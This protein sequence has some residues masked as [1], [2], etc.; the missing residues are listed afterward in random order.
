MKNSI[1]HLHAV[2]QDWTRELKFY[3]SETPIFKKRLEEIVQKNT[4]H[5]ILAQVEHFE[6]KF[7]IMNLHFDELI[8][9]LRLMD[10]A[11][12]KEAT[13]KPNF[14]SLK[15][16]DDDTNLQELM[17]FTASDF[18]GTKKEFYQFLAKYL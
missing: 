13:Q 3:K 7:A 14:I 2:C 9:D 10:E 1:S 12:L 16:I 5:E 15:I 17:D 11:L 6:N 18:G 8:H 4:S